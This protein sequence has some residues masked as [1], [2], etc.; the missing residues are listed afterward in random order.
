MVKVIYTHVC[1]DVE[2]TGLDPEKDEILEITAKEFNLSGA[3]G[4]CLTF[5]CKPKS[6]FISKEASD[7]NGITMEMVKECPNYLE[8]GVREKIAEFIGD[9]TVIGH[10]IIDFDIKFIKIKP[11]IIEDTLVMSRSRFPGRSNKL[12]TACGRVGIEF[13]YLKAHRSEYDVDKTIELY[14]KLKNFETKKNQLKLEMP[15]FSN[16]I[17]QEIETINNQAQ[18]GVILSDSDQKMIATQ[19]YSYSRINLF[20][21]CPFKWFMQYIKGIKQ[22]DEDYLIVGTVVH[23]I[24]EKSGKWCFREL[25]AN[26]FAEFVKISKCQFSEDNINNVKAYYNKDNITFHDVGRYL[27]ENQEKINKYFPEAK[28]FYKFIVTM[29]N[30]LKE[31]NVTYDIPAMPSL[32]EYENIIQNLINQYKVTDPEII[33]DI[34][35]LAEKFYRTSNFSILPG[36]IVL[37][38]KRFAFD[39]NWNILSDFYAHNAFFRG[40]IDMIFYYKRTII[41]KDYKTS[42]KIMSEKELAEDMQLAIYVLMIYKFIPRNSYDTIIA[43]VEYIR[44]GKKIRLELKNDAIDGYAD[45][46]L[47]WILDSIQEIEKEMLKTDGAFAPIRNEYCHSCHIGGDGKC[48]LF[49]K[50]FINDIGDPFNFIIDSIDDCV[51]AWKRIEA[52]KSENQRLTKLC[53][54]FVKNCETS[55]KID[56]NAILDFYTKNTLSFNPIKTVQLFL[57]KG[58]P[59]EEI[60]S[61][62]SFPTSQVEKFIE[63]KNL[64]LTEEEISS[65][66]EQTT[67]TEFDAFTP[68][69]AKSKNFLNS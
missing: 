54:A 44:F 56:G 59:I 13:D 48:P 47:R 51:N 64:K 30:V 41:I 8:D 1:I 32:E 24:A 62:M 46:A 63:F 18:T 11:K 35:R 29:D 65:I 43:E 39:K 10:N 55:I 25:F 23:A 33:I 45:K 16:N 68:E 52:N 50:A 3:T 27:F 7:V 6:G 14:L 57:R 15:I 34:R 58:A 69:E 19:T 26:K 31:A 53:K 40:I 66:S 60:L 2:T 12:K 67:K 36:D 20:K 42:R 28:G 5:L 22:P 17:N 37:T 61:F 49:N 4:Q 38:E 9:R 21:Q